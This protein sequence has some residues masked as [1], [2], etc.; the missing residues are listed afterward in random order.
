MPDA[1]AHAQ[2]EV[3][4]VGRESRA[5][6]LAFLASRS[7]DVA[8]AEDAL[9]DAMQAAL[10]TWPRTG[11]PDVPEAWLLVSARRRLVDAARHARV[12][13]AAASLILA[14]TE[15]AQH[16]AQDHARFPDKR[17]ELLFVCAHPAI[18]ASARAPLMLQVVLGLDASRIASAF[19]VRPAAMGQRLARAKAK[20][21]EAGIAFQVP[22]AREL[23][24]RLDA[25]LDAIYAAY[26]SG[27]HDVAGADAST[28]GLAA[29][30]I[31]LG[32]LLAQLLPDEPEPLGLLALMLYCESRR[33]ARRNAAGEYV[34][35]AQQDVTRWSRAM[36]DEA[37]RLLLRAR[38]MQRIGRFQ[39]EAA[40]QS[41]HA[42]RAVSGSTDSDAICL[43]YERLIEIAPSVG[44]RVGHAAAVAQARGA[45]AGVAIMQAIA[46]DEIATYQPYWALAAHLYR[47][48]G[49][50]IDAAQAYRQAIGL[51]TD[52]AT[53]DFLVR[54]SLQIAPSA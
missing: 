2:R 16:L 10:E 45:A 15:E 34:P 48:L 3:E 44:A 43:L 1:G 38:A 49:R 4:R 51:A 28:R 39:L 47:E 32:A 14:A 31:D 24:A 36:I 27:W 54:K 52:D 22:D 21:R 25:V 18:D 17:L 12:H 8:A 6:L 11:V 46:V 50:S 26:G 40:I 13:D 29:E 37:E 42:Q 41:A 33:G 19:V 5:R 53:R 20:I 9:A 23:A 30:A 7:R 35:L